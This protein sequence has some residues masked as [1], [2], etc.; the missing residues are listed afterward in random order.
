MQQTKSGKQARNV[1]RRKPPLDSRGKYPRTESSASSYEAA[2]SRPSREVASTPENYSDPYGESILGISVP[3]VSA[4]PDSY[5]TSRMGPAS[6][7]AT[8]SSR[9]ASFNTQKAPQSSL[10]PN[11][12]PLNPVYVHDSGSSTRR[13]E[14]PGNFSRT[15]TPTSMSSQS[16]GVGTPAK[17]PL[18][19]QMSPTRSRP[20]VTRR[21]FPAEDI[22]PSQSRG[23]TAVRESATSSSSSS[24]IKAS[25]QRRDGSQVRSDRSTPLPPSPPTRQTSK[26][27]ATVENLGARRDYPT[28]D[29][30]SGTAETSQPP[31]SGRLNIHGDFSQL[32]RF[33]SPPPPR[34]SRE[35]TPK[36]DEAF[37]PLPKIHS[38]LSPLKIAGYRPRLSSDKDNP[39]PDSRSGFQYQSRTALGRSPSNASS[40]S[41]M[42]SR[43]PSPNLNAARSLK[44]DTGEPLRT[45]TAPPMD[46]SIGSNRFTK[47]PS[48]LSAI[49]TKSTGRFGLFTKRTRSPLEIAPVESADKAAKKGPAAG[50]G[51]EGYSKYSRR[52]RSGSTSTSASRGRSTSSTS[53]GRTP[54]SRKS[55]FTSRDEPMDDF[56]SARLAPVVISGGGRGQ[57]SPFHGSAHY[58]TSS[59]DSSAGMTSNED[60]SARGLTPL[61]QAPVILSTDASST[62]N[63]RRD[64]RRLPH[65]RD[66]PDYLLEQQQREVFDPR[67]R[68]TLA[69]RRSAH[70]SQLFGQEGEPVKVPAPI[71][72]R[73]RTVS[74]GMDSR[75]T[76]Q[77]SIRTDTSD[78][79]AEGREGNWLRSRRSEKRA[80]SPRKGWNFF[81]R[82]Q[83]SP[84]RLPESAIPKLGDDQAN[85]KELP[86]IVSEVPE[87]RSL[88]FYALL[89]G[90]EQENLDKID[91]SLART[92]READANH[93]LMAMRT[94]PPDAPQ[95]QEDRLSTLLPSP[96]NLTAEFS[97]QPSKTTS[98]AELN[99]PEAALQT[100]PTP[101]AEPK[102]PRLQQ[103]GRIPRVISKRDRPHKPPPQSF[104]RPFARHPTV[105]PEPQPS[106]PMQREPGPPERPPLAIQTEVIPFDDWGTPGSSKPASA[107]VQ[108]SQ[109]FNGI[110]KGEFLS[111]PPRTAS[112]ISGV[113]GS[114]SSGTL[115]LA[116]TTA[117]LPN[118]GTAPEED[119]IWNEYNDFLDTVGSSP[120]QL[121]ND[122]RN[123]LEA[124]LQ[125]KRWVPPPL[126][127]SKEPSA[128][129]SP[130]RIR[131]VDLP[132]SSAPT[133]PLPS[134]PDRSKLFS[135]DFPS[136]PG[137]ISDLLASYGD[138]NRSSVGSNRKSGYTASRYSTSSIESDAM[139][140]TS[141]EETLGGSSHR[142]EMSASTQPFV[143][144][145]LR[146]KALMTSRWLSFGRV[147]FSPARTELDNKRVLVL[148]GLGNDDWSFYCAETCGNAIVFNLSPTPS[149]PQQH[150]AAL[151]LP[152]NHRQIQLTSLMNR[153]PFPSDFFVAAIVRFPAANSEAGY[154]NTISECTRTLRP[155]GYLEASILDL[156][157]VNMGNKARKALR[158]LKVRMQVAQPDVALTSVSDIVQTTV[159]RKGFENLKSVPINIPVAGV[160]SNSR[161]NSIDA[162]SGIMHDLSTDVS[163][164]RDGSLAQTLPQV[165]RWWFTQCYE[166]SSMPYDD[167]E[168]S[169]WNDKR[170]LEECEKKATGFKLSL[171]YAQKPAIPGNGSGSSTKQIKPS[172]LRGL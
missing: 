127:I 71:D 27:L 1:L 116:A 121:S 103:V 12:P 124:M 166:I 113:S 129:S 133:R 114:S 131:L 22:Q 11:L 167:M 162:K 163:G 18:R 98:P 112:H 80:K 141:R 54:T 170:L 5:V 122:S 154:L 25:E 4:N 46:T 78:D 139:S 81:Q 33:K 120:A 156:D 69:A 75:D 16:P 36:L 3:N 149:R 21:K 49:S 142:A 58:P 137:T 109:T 115:S 132:A 31:Q 63:L 6:E 138:R 38:G 107:P 150:N 67:Q 68:P 79:I 52:G 110:A 90:S 35:G 95:A 57:E 118:P 158:D 59:G 102:K 29:Q 99:T 60:I 128:T 8:S 26:R 104:S 126:Q 172:Q 125:K 73:A 130:E 91:T 134:P 160:V 43:M 30:G 15:S 161:S 7:F 143:Q 48:P 56:L 23:L 123:P 153:F 147:L 105:V 152:K 61:E 2:P 74:P 157:M 84:R 45:R 20:P 72:V 101:V 86:T 159:K 77:S 96:P 44:L 85:V 117:L 10:T 148:D 40:A 62:H 41:F 70:R 135:A 28:P 9:M 92:T 151:R 140:F 100:E 87:P 14:S 89:D 155:G 171:F 97:Y 136:S 24:T 51:H 108:Q 76:V 165:G 93:S 83:A 64:Y 119:E 82:A 32:N 146:F 145:D 164:N 50:T 65:R 37:E 144:N 39:N 94:G 169:I 13:S 53:A 47:E 17:I 111:F 66:H 19:R 106:Y 42:P 34:P 55:S 168:R 88:P